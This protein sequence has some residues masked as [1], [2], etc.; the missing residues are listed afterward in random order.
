M[1]RGELASLSPER[2]RALCRTGEFAGPTSG[3]AAGH[4]QANLVVLPERYAH[5][6]L[7]FCDRNPKPCPVLEV[8]E[9]G[10]PLLREMAE[11]ADLRT[12]LPRY[13]VF[14]NGQLESEVTDLLDLWRQDFVGF[15]LG[16]SYTFDAAL[17]RAGIH[18]RHLARK[19]VVS[20]YRTSRRCVPAGI[21]AGPL[22]VSMRP[23]PEAQVPA[24]VAITARYPFAHGAPVHVGDPAAL[25]IRDLAAVSE[26]DPTPVEP[27]E[28]PVFW[29]CGVTPQAVAL[30]AR[31]EIMIT[32]APGHMLVCDPTDEELQA[33]GSTAG[34]TRRRVFN[35]ELPAGA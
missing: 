18:L 12:D 5:D 13:R 1:G 22:V 23:I 14:L 9:V 32:H 3:L 35:L 2:I 15:L 17:E 11:G 4:V 24:A 29:A 21:F 28:V 10:S 8:T 27:G 30:K 20:M 33:R 31:P 7:L 16:C 34:C 26:G 25:G 19:A 6:F